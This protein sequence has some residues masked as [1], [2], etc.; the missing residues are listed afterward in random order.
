M[1]RGGGRAIAFPGG[2]IRVS[3]F[4]LK[5]LPL[6]QVFKLGDHLERSFG[7]ANRFTKLVGLIT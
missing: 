4:A 3:R 6:T 7:G 2:Y 1:I 5:R